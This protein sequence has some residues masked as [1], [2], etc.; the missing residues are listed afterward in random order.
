MADKKK[1]KVA[2]EPKA[3]EP[4]IGQ[5]IPPEVSPAGKSIDERM[6]DLLKDHK[7]MGAR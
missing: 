4:K 6:A 1:A 3:D 5:P 2:E 7:K